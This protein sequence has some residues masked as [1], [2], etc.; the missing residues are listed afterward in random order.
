MRVGQAL[1]GLPRRGRRRGTVFV[2][3]PFEG[4]PSECDIIALRELVP[5]ATAPLTVK[6]A[7]A[8]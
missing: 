7:D 3:R 2:A 4:L 1:Q 8:P 6:G 5:A